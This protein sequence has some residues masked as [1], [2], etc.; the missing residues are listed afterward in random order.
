MNLQGLELNA[1]W[2]SWYIFYMI[3]FTISWLFTYFFILDDIF[4]YSNN[5]LILE[6]LFIA[7]LALISFA[8]FCS[9][10]LSKVKQSMLLNMIIIASY[11]G[12]FFNTINPNYIA[13]LPLANLCFI[14]Q[15]IYK[16][17]GFNT[18]LTAETLTFNLRN[19]FNYNSSKQFFIYSIFIFYILS[20]YLDKVIPTEHGTK[21]KP[22]FCITCLK[23]KKKKEA[24]GE[25]AGEDKENEE[26]EKAEEQ[27]KKNNILKQF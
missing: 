18:G 13:I 23:K 14:F 16:L 22:W 7:S 24:A 8:I 4:I 6:I 17:E 25:A 27:E 26:E 10:I 11:I 21:E 9:S 12:A 19:N 3:L 5:N 15:I 2:L 1:Y 20:I